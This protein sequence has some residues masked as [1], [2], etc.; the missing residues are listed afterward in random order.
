MD[1]MCLI[2]RLLWKTHCGKRIALENAVQVREVQP[3]NHVRIVLADDNSTFL[4]ELSLLLKGEFDVVATAKNGKSAL[5]LIRDYGPDLVVLDI[6]MPDLNGIDVCRQL[7]KTPDRPR[8]VFC[9]LE[10]DLDIVKAAREMGVLAYVFKS[11]V[12]TDL[13]PAIK[14]ALE[15]KSFVSTRDNGFRK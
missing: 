9:S 11:R 5:D 1:P 13:L 14:L 15:G 3:L 10:T 6:G 8:I 12:A 4:K 7:A 2:S